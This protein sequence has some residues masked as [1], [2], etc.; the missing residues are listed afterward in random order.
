MKINTQYPPFTDF[1]KNEFK[2]LEYIQARGFFNSSFQDLATNL[3]NSYSSYKG[4]DFSE[5][6]FKI[7]ISFHMVV[8]KQIHKVI[9]GANIIGEEGINSYFLALCD[10]QEQ[11]LIRKFHF[12]YALPEITTNQRVPIF[13]LQYGGKSTQEMLDDGLEDTKLDNWLSIPRLSFAPMNLALLLDMILCEFTN[14]DAVQIHE[15][16]EW[17]D[18]IYK[19]EKFLYE[20]YFNNLHSH[21]N[22]LRHNKKYLIRDFHYGQ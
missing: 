6:S 18:L 9:L 10:E 21:M 14:N 5:N 16:P 17:R 22:S 13:H 4:V 20:Q 7:H 11:Q 1:K 19:N 2:T 12:D 8:E 3:Y 15:A